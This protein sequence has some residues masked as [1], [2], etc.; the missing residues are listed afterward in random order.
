MKKTLRM[1]LTVMV[2][3]STVIA[4][5]AM[6]V[7]AQH[8]DGDSIIENDDGVPGLNDGNDDGELDEELIEL[9][10]PNDDGQGDEGGHRVPQ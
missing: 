9:F 3:A 1:T 7:A 2:L 10:D 6:P 8:T 4:I 5:A